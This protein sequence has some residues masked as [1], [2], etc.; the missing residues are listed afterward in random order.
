MSSDVRG[1]EHS[2]TELLGFT[3]KFVSSVGYTQPGEVVRSAQL[4]RHVAESWSYKP[5]TSTHLVQDVR[6]D[7]PAVS[8]TSIETHMRCMGVPQVANAE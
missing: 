6:V 2:R 3:D 8:H 7:I 4:S 5:T 1:D